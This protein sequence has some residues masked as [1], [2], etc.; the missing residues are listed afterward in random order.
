VSTDE[1]A[2]VRNTSE[3][4]NIVNAGLPL[5]SGDEVVV[6]DQ[7]HPTN[8]VAWEVRAARYNL[9]VRKVSIPRIVE[10]AGEL[11]EV[12]KK[13]IGPR[14][15][16]LAITHVSNVS[17]VRLPIR[18]ICEAAH[19]RG[20]YVHVDGAQ[21]WGCLSVNLRE[22]GCD[23]YTASSHKW[24]MGPKEAG[25]LFV[26][27]TWIPE[28]WPGCV[29]PG[30]GDDVDPDVA[31]ARKFESLGQR[32]DACLAAV[33]VA[34]DLHFGLGPSKIEQRVLELSGQLKAGCVKLGLK[35]VTP[36]APE[37]SAG[38]C[39][40]ELEPGKQSEVFARLYERY[41]VA[42]ATTGGLRLCPHVYNTPDHVERALGALRELRPL[43][44]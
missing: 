42:G 33:G 44:A 30:W 40:L 21:T 24:F 2:L 22:L 36:G 27:S 39:V 13:S 23:S 20:V 15:R 35:L 4:N 43:F 11:V 16:V 26:S 14:T 3:G 31:G 32:D 6:W 19:Q 18:E 10:D 37:L 12:F 1:I 9:V 38:V 17:G 8:N 28:I 41:G 5:E 7:N 34:A 25:V 29:A